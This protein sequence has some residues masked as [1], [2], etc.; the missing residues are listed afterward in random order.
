VLGVALALIVAKVLLNAAASLVFRWS[1]PGSTQLGFLL[2][3]GSEFALVIF[4]LP[5][6]R[7]LLGDAAASVLIAAVALSLALTPT[8]AE[9]GRDLAGRLRRRRKTVNDPELIAR[10]L[11]AP[12]MIVGMGEVGRTLADALTEF[13]IRYHAI[14]RDQ[15]RFKEANADGY[16][17]SFGD[18]GDPR[19]WE[20]VAMQGRRVLAL[21]APDYS[22]S[23]ALTP[24]IQQL[25]PDVKRFAAVADEAERERFSRIGLT[26]VLDRSVPRGLGLAGAVLAEL[27][28]DADAVAL[29]NKRQRER[30]EEG[31]RIA[32]A[33]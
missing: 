22:V 24:L 26:A 29:W 18:S 13:D 25:Y 17:V 20:P 12:V 6:I 10:D 8:L 21:T 4:S 33:A 15:Q 2:A 14:E 16:S 3:Q 30:R 23:S 7:A 31:E 5:P 1:V 27:G 19:I 11:T 9:L 28:V 32:E